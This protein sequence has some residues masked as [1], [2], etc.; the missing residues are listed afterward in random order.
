MRRRGGYLTRAAMWLDYRAIMPGLARLSWRLAI[1]W[2]RRRGDVLRWSR[3]DGRRVAVANL[4]RAY[5]GTLASDEAER[6]VRGSFRA[7]TCEEAEA[8]FFSDLAGERLRRFLAVEG[9]EHLDAALA[10]GRGAIVFSSHFGSMCLAMVGLA[11]LGYRVNVLARSLEPDDNPLAVSVRRYA[12]GKVATL[13][14]ILERPFIIAGKPG[15]MQQM[16]DA[17]AAGELVYILIS[18]PPELARQR[19]AV[20]F[21]G[22]PAELPLGI[23]LIAEATRAALVPFA[24]Y[25]AADR[26]GHTLVIHQAIGGPEAGPGTLQ[27]CADAIERDI[28]ADPAQFFMWEF[29]R[30][31]WTDGFDDHD[32]NRYEACAHAS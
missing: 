23:E 4:R 20:R 10:R 9:R 19:G 13:E 1:W 21:L 3:V 17:L 7:Q 31:F 24:V 26:L 6:I 5:G 14:R 12:E 30:S 15:S 11:R 18:V 2:G 25:R 16:R 29:A 22:H 27:R 28:R 32:H 8:Y